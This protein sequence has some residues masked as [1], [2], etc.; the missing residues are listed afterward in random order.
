MESG[1]LFIP[2]SESI[3]SQV[4]LRREWSRGSCSPRYAGAVGERGVYGV[5][6][7]LRLAASVVEE[8]V[9]RVGDSSPSRLIDDTGGMQGKGNNKFSS[10]I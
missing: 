4:A 10:M 9:D 8:F 7:V 1:V 5:D 2:R 3:K 6:M